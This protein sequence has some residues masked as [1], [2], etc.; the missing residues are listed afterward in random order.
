MLTES[1]N[2]SGLAKSHLFGSK[3]PQV[4]GGYQVLCKLE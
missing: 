1:Q 4:F 3:Q 2:I